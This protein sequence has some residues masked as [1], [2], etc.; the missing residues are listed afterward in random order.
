MVTQI[1]GN[2]CRRCGVYAGEEL[3]WHNGCVYCTWDEEDDEQVIEFDFD[4]LKETKMDNEVYHGMIGRII[5]PWWFARS[6]GDDQEGSPGQVSFDWEKIMEREDSHGDI[7][8]FYHT[9]PSF[10]GTPSSTDYA[11]MGAWTLSLGR[12][13]LCLIEGTDGLNAN[14]FKDDE[15]EHVRAKVRK[16][17]KWYVGNVP[18]FK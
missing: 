6:F 14:W 4:D 3:T 10:P 15:S 17:G 2:R 9:H 5:G 16:F 11:T 12:P 7:V 1:D 13:L 18:R 8:G